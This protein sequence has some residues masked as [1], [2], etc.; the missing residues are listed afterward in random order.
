MTRDVVQFLPPHGAAAPEEALRAL[1]KALRARQL[2]GANNPVRAASLE[3]ARAALLLAWEVADPLVLQVQRDTLLVCLDD[4]PAEPARGSE[5]LAALLFAEGIRELRL[6][7]GIEQG[8]LAV[9]LDILGRARG[10]AHGDDD[11]VTQLW[12]ADL[13][14]CDIRHVEVG[15]E[16]GS[17]DGFAPVLGD[18]EAGAVPGADS[19]DGGD[20]AAW[21]E[22]SDHE[23][24]R[25]DGSRPALPASVD[26]EVPG[27]LGA[28]KPPAIGTRVEEEA[29]G[30]DRAERAY[31]DA[32][33][34]RE[35]GEAY[36]LNVL[37]ALLDIALL[38]I[39]WDARLEAVVALDALL[40]EM[41]S[42]GQFAASAVLLE[43]AADA[44]AAVRRDD[45]THE[46]L[47]RLVRRV[48]EPEL[49]QSL[50]QALADPRRAPTVE[51]ARQL[52][53][54]LHPS[55]LPALIT[56]LGTTGPSPLRG[57]VEQ[58]AL[59]FAAR[60]PEALATLLGSGE[61]AVL[62]GALGLAAARPSPV[63][64]PALCR[65][66]RHADPAVRQQ[67]L[68][69]VATM[70]STGVAATLAGACTDPE[71]SVRMAAYRAVVARR[72]EAA[73]APLLALVVKRGFVALDV[74][75]Q[76]ALFEALGS[77]AD[78]AT[79]AVLDR[80]LNASGLL[81]PKESPEVRACA[82]RALG[83][84]GTA[85]AQRA[86]AAAREAR[87]PLVQRAVR[88]ALGLEGVA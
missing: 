18:D 11:L 44:M 30:L 88:R 76:G 50:L 64:A 54:V 49:L 70:E 22:S 21:R 8:E 65:A 66:A 78:D 55:T 46:A 3:A 62:V 19:V 2:Y 35:A 40:L 25:A 57:C 23:A 47:G 81:G 73:R 32:W 68:A 59:D 29:P 58:T 51:V 7:S 33:I 80:F 60:H 52:L 69:L 61:P 41:L 15:L 53:A 36:R 75:E 16:D 72:P 31:L 86:L 28:P 20:R 9:L 43:G 85:V 34:A 74:T 38:D 24:P 84:A 45:G 67:A 39:E 26:E 77:V 56:W 17:V 82:A 10:G 12:L 83:R 48:S 5:P 14:H 63:L 1:I 37:L 87:E 27:F 42:M 71:R 79:V 13:V 6:A 4:A